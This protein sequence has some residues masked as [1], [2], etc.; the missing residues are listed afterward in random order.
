MLLTTPEKVN[1]FCKITPE[2]LRLTTE[3]Y[4]AFIESII[5]QFSAIIL[6]Y[7]GNITEEE[8]NENEFLKSILEHIILKMINKFLLQNSKNK[9]MS[10]NIETEISE[11]VNNDV[12]LTDEIKG[13]LRKFRKIKIKAI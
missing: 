7:T 13:I 10:I 5:F 1:I 4:N 12:I 11:N 9:I 6:E 2:D 3:E 8:I